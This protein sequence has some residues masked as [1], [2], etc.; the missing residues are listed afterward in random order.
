[1]AKQATIVEEKKEITKNPGCGDHPAP[2]WQHH[3]ASTRPKLFALEP[4]A[5]LST[6]SL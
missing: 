5:R 6:P 1:M 3:K 2:K 4:W